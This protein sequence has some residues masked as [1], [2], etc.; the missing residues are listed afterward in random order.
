MFSGILPLSAELL[1]ANGELSHADPV[2]PILIASIFITFGAVLG[3][4]LS[5]RRFSENFW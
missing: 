4:A 2:V 3:G 5:S 1:W